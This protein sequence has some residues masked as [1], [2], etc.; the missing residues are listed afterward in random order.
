MP[1]MEE[2]KYS[3]I[4]RKIIGCAMNVH[5]YLGSGFQEVIYQRA[6]AYEFE[7]VQLNFVREVE[8]EIFYK[9]KVDPIGSRKVDFLVED[10][11]LVELKATNELE[12]A[13]FAQTLNYL[14][15]YKVEVGLLINF[16]EKSLRY[17]RLIH[18]IQ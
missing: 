11:V 13:H 9:D 17:K 7:L 4:T 16:G 8:M 2:Y 1:L 6:L 10:K 12:A 18:S 3:D 5:K 15:A 14:R